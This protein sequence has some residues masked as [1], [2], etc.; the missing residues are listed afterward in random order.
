MLRH[1]TADDKH[2][3]SHPA[4]GSPEFARAASSP[5][6]APFRPTGAQ[7]GVRQPSAQRFGRSALLVFD[8][9]F[10]VVLRNA[11]AETLVSTGLI[12]ID[13]QSRLSGSLAVKLRR[14]IDH[15]QDRAPILLQ[16]ADRADCYLGAFVTPVQSVGEGACALYALI[17][18]DA[19]AELQDRV[20]ALAQHNRLTEQ[21]QR[22]LMLIV[23]GKNPCGAAQA[24]G[25]ARSTARTHLQRCFEKMGVTR[26]S[27]LVSLVARFVGVESASG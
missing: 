3:T 5:P 17:V 24:L 2:P 4:G 13:A 22:M 11:E 18:R 21:E 20:A 8:S 26:Q 14:R 6:A 25:V 1:A 23:E 19:L 15:P 9:Q 7:A 27:E 12:E 16:G 10:V